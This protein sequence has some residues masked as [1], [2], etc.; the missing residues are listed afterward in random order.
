VVSVNPPVLKLPE[1]LLLPD[2]PFTPPEALQEVALLED[3]RRV[4]LPFELT[5]VLSAERETLGFWTWFATFIV[6][7]SLSDPALLVQVRLKVVLFVRLP[8]LKDP[9]VAFKP[10]QPFVPPEALQEVAFVEDQRMVVFP[11]KFKFVLSAERET[12]GFGVCWQEPVTKTVTEAVATV[13]LVEL[14]P[15]I[16]KVVV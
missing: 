14:L 4:V 12:V 1:R 15:V 5:F 9:D 6:T 13:L 8:V 2:Q 7:E 16:V 10:D 3:Q 11:P